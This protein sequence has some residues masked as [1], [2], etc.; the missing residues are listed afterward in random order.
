MVSPIGILYVHIINFIQAPTRPSGIG[1]RKKQ[2]RPSRASTERI[3]RERKRDPKPAV[4]KQNI[5]KRRPSENPVAP[6]SQR[7]V[8]GPATSSKRPK[9]K[10]KQADIDEIAEAAP[11]LHHLQLVSKPRRIS[12]EQIAKWPLCSQQIQD[13]IKFVLQRAR[14]EVMASRRDDRRREEARQI[15]NKVFRD[16]ERQLSMV[17]VPP[18][19][20]D[21]HFNLDWL[22][23]RNERLRQEVTTA[24]HS[25]QLL[26]E[27]VD[28]AKVQLKKDEKELNTLKKDAARWKEIQ[29][30][31]RKLHPLLTLPKNF[32]MDGDGPEDIGLKKAAPVDTAMLDAPGPDIAPLIGQLRRSLES[33]QDNHEQVEGIHEA[34]QNVQAALD[35]FLFKHASSPQYDAL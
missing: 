17:K 2:R 15:L 6:V 26:E 19:T 9:G 27:Q 16:L 28:K 33:L 1:V 20:R 25:N 14:D 5:N 3:S 24:R 32:K 35:G 13:Q 21:I 10:A 30:Q 22:T 23:E 11:V 31:S 8:A 4:A 29:K 18:H 7:N 34:M 12:E